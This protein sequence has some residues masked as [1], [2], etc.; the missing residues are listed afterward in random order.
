MEVKRLKRMWVVS[1]EDE[2]IEKSAAR[3][4]SGYIQEVLTAQSQMGDANNDRKKEGNTILHSSGGGRHD[5]I[6]DSRRDAA[7]LG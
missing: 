3:R 1:L 7:R 4:L 5:A 6:Y 2:I